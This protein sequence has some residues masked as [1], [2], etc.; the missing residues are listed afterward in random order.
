MKKLDMRGITHDIL[1]VA[2]V[3]I[4]AIAG[5]AYL[6][7]SHAD[8]CLKRG[9]VPITAASAPASG[10]CTNTYIGCTISGLP[11]QGVYGQ[12]VRPQ[13][14]LTNYGPKSSYARLHVDNYVYRSGPNGRLTVLSKSVFVQSLSGRHRS[15]HNMR[16]VRVGYASPT[17]SSIVYRAVFNHSYAAACDASMALPTTK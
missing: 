6:V 17:T 1:L 16:S 10:S 11:R 2:F 15:I 13:L 8:P 4:F 7:A 9:N 14:I 3:A 12:I 5:V